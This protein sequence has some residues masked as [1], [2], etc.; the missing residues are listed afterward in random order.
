MLANQLSE[1]GDITNKLVDFDALINDIQIL[2]IDFIQVDDVVENI[3][4]GFGAA[5]NRVGPTALF[6]TQFG[7]EQT[8]SQTDDTVKRGS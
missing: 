3:T 2:A 8:T 6:L 4:Q 5:K 7:F 1:V